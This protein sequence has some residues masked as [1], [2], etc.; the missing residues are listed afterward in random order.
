MFKL[1]KKYIR[2][3]ASIP[4]FDEYCPPDEKYKELIKKNYIDTNKILKASTDLSADGKIQTTTIIWNTSDD[5][6]DF[7]MDE[8]Y[9]AKYVR[10]QHV[11]NLKNNIKTETNC[12]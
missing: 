8:S 12:V 10:T 11:Y 9:I 1:I 3:D 2:E 4:F 7:I 6:L 5:F